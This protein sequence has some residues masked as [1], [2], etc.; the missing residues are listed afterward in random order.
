[1]SETLK[2]LTKEINKLWKEHFQAKFP[3]DFY[4]QEINGVDFVTL[5]SSIA[6]CISTFAEDGN[7]NLYQT[8]VLGLCYREVSFILPIL[9]EPDAEYFRRLERLAELV[10]K[11]VARKNLA[12]HLKSEK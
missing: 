5:D 8:A 1:M 9:N 12:A 3:E 7:L 6:G 11:A 2:S 4:G 10:L